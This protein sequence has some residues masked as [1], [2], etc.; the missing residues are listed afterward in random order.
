MPGGLLVPRTTGKWPVLLTA[1]PRVS[2]PALW[3]EAGDLSF[4]YVYPKLDDLASGLT[5]GRQCL[6]DRSNARGRSCC[7]PL[8]KVTLC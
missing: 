5:C 1:N 6:R 3:V 7:P 4:V 2:H 8:L